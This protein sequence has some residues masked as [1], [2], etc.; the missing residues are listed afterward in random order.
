LG[1]PGLVWASASMHHM[2][3][4]DQA[5]RHVR[6]LLAP[7]GLFALLELSGFPRFLPAGE[8]AALEERA[9]TASD[10]FHAEHVPHRGAEWGPK[11][12]E[13]GFTIAD[14]RTL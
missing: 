6:E 8:E 7:E 10:R 4:P 11:L 2:A 9:H 14:E 12:T 13:A 1:T 5:L 3:D